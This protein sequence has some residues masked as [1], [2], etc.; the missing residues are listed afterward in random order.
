MIARLRFYERTDREIPI[1]HHSPGK[2]VTETEPHGAQVRLVYTTQQSSELFPDTT[3]EILHATRRVAH[4]G[5]VESLVNGTGQL[6]VGNDQLF[7]NSRLGLL[8][9]LSIGTTGTGDR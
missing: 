3:V 4:D 9:L 1:V 7:L 8:A 5:D 6:G 2:T